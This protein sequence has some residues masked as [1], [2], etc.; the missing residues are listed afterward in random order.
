[1]DKN[2]ETLMKLAT[3]LDNVGMPDAA[4][5]AVAVADSVRTGDVDDAEAVAFIARFS[6]AFAVAEH[7]AAGGSPDDEII[8][9]PRL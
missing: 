4:D 5:F 1:M 7:V 8:A 9:L 6:L 2:A 3:L